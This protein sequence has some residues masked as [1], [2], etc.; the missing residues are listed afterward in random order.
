MTGLRIVIALAIGTFAAAQASGGTQRTRIIPW[1]PSSPIMDHLRPDDETVIVQK[2]GTED[3]HDAASIVMSR[4]PLS[5]QLDALARADGIA[6]VQVMTA[7][8]ELVEK[9]TW[10]DTVAEL[11]LAQVIRAREPL[12]NANVARI[13]I[14][15][16]ELR[17]NGVTIRA[18]AFPVLPLQEQLLVFLGR[19]RTCSCWRL[20]D[21]YSISRT[22]QLSAV[23]R[24]N[25]SVFSA[26]QA[27]IGQP[28]ASVIDEL[29]RRLK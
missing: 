29:N 6:V 4:G 28:L 19:S 14:R 13:S 24:S 27:L 2:G 23:Q 7:R 9:G 8:G 21:A 11:R 22:N 26:G 20:V 18:G 1:S 5:E 25:G 3:M 15:N 10:V 16:G 12:G 17:R